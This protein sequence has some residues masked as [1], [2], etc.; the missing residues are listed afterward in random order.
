MTNI[1]STDLSQR[2][3]IRSA[4]AAF[5]R[6][7]LKSERWSVRAAALAIGTNHTSLGARVKGDTAFFAEDIESIAILLKRNPIEF[8]GEYLRAGSDDSDP[9]TLVP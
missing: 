4:R 5:V 2:D 8:Y 1:A 3:V 9:R 6:D 7:A